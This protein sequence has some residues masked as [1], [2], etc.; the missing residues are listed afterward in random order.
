M[1]HKYI[2]YLRK[3]TDREDMQVQSIESQ[4]D[5]CIPLAR[6]HGL[7]IVDEIEDRE[8]AKVPGR[9]GF[10]KLIE[11]VK[12]GEVQG[13]LA[14]HPDRLARNSKDGGDI[15]YLLDTGELQDL[16]FPVFWF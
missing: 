10:A 14:Y 9:D 15:I 13:I 16:K 5:V 12:S 2:L 3:S 11:R 4:R 7:Q 8:S 1:N 6:Q